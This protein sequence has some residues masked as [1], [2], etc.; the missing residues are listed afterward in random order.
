MGWR[1]NVEK[2]TNGKLLLLLP[3]KDWEQVYGG[4]I[5]I[6]CMTKLKT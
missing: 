2:K 1:D 6:T 5:R 3:V 4:P